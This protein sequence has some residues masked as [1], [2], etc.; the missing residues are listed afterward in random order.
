MADEVAFEN[1]RISKLSRARD[2]DL[3]SGHTAYRHA[4][5]IDLYLPI[6]QISLKSK[7]RFVD[8]RTDA[9][10]RPALLGRLRSVDLNNNNNNNNNAISKYSTDTGIQQC[11]YRSV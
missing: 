7:K 4:S 8:G 2:I 3:G 9:H 5:L 1:G 6:R 10:L 11:I